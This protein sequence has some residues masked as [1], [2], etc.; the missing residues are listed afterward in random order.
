MTVS[1]LNR[2][3]AQ[4]NLVN[5]SHF[6]DLQKLIAEYPYVSAFRLLYQKGLG[7]ENDVICD[8]ELHR[9]ALYAPNR[10]Q[11]M[12]LLAK[13]QTETV[14]EKGSA[15]VASEVEKNIVP[16]K[17]ETQSTKLS[18]L[19][20][21]IAEPAD[22]QSA[23]DDAVG[24]GTEMKFGAEVDAFLSHFAEA[25]LKRKAEQN[26][27]SNNAPLKVQTSAAVNDDDDADDEALP[28]DKVETKPSGEFFTETLAKIY[29]KQE[30]F[31]KAID[32]FEHLCLK[33]PEKSA[34]FAEQIRFLKKL[35]KYL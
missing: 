22:D 15:P 11:L 2:L 35:I 7:N 21:T 5:S 10:N 3:I 28:V 34:Y 26:A 12:L 6:S 25:Q 27:A 1:E 14:E 32:I 24:A 19:A 31:E 16:K 17:A 33:Y 13:K 18:S 8:A 23:D 29:I 30:K 9:T 20:K 4:P